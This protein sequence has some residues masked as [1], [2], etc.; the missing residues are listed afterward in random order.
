VET[1]LLTKILWQNVAE[2]L[3]MKTRSSIFAPR[4]NRKGK[5]KKGQRKIKT[6]FVISLDNKVK[7]IV[8]LHPALIGSASEGLKGKI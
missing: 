8:S 4:F 7:Q 5:T 6:F 3:A 2:P 1:E